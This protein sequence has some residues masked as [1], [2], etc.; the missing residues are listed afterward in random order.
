MSSQKNKPKNEIGYDLWSSI[1]DRYPNPTVAID[2]ISFPE[3]YSTVK[4]MNVLEV[5]CGTG[6]HTLRLISANNEVTGVDLSE[7]MLSQLRR[8]VETPRLKLIKGDFLCTEIQGGPFDAIIAS[9]VLE[10]ISDLS[11]FFSRARSVLAEGGLLFISD[12]HPQRMQAGIFA[13]FKDEAGNEIALESVAHQSEQI[14]ESAKNN[15]FLVKAEE[16]VSGTEQLVKINSKWIRYFNVPMIQIWVMES[17][18]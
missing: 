17:V 4:D 10:H 14:R 13:H 12:L 6:R 18:R 1:Y 11:L 8:K 5:G 2:D 15:G 7:G 9:L 16:S 3:F